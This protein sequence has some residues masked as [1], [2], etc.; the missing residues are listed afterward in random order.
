LQLFC[1]RE[2]KNLSRIYKSQ[3]EEA[4]SVTGLLVCLFLFGLLFLLIFP[5]FGC[6]GGAL[7]KGQ[8]TQTLSNMKQLHLATQSMALE[9]GKDPGQKPRLAWRHG[10]NVYQ[11]DC[12]V[13]A[14]LSW[15]ER[16]L[17]IAIR[18]RSDS[19]TG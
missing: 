10:R 19:S 8:M 18:P 1:L 5:G 2:I 13:G 4:L 7:V 12:T 16:F 3:R 14:F 6:G 17:Q 15:V 9:G 11:L